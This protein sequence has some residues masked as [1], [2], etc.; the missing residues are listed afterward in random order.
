MVAE[1]GRLNRT[2]G[3]EHGEWEWVLYVWDEAGEIVSEDVYDSQ[4]EAEARAE[5]LMIP[6]VER[7]EMP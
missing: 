5:F 6:I 7:W 3:L 1:G 2:A 4:Q